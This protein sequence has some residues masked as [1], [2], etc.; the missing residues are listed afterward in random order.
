[1]VNLMDIGVII[2]SLKSYGGAQ[3]C[4]L[5]C[6]NLWQK[7][8]DITLYT[9]NYD[10]RITENYKLDIDIKILNTKLFPRNDHYHQFF[11]LS[12]KYLHKQV[13]DHDIFNPHIF[14]SFFIHKNP[15][16]YYPQEPLRIAYDLFDFT[17]Q[18][19]DISNYVKFSLKL[20]MP[21]LKYLDKKN[22]KF[23]SIVANSHFSKKYLEDTYKK[24]CD[25]VYL[26]VDFENFKNSDSENFIL[27]VSRFDSAKRIE[28]PI[29]TMRYLNSFKMK[30]VGKGSEFTT[31]KLK[32]LVKKLKL[33]DKIE[34]IEDIN[35]SKLIELY[36]KCFCTIFTPLREPF[37]M[38]ALESMAA[39][40]P[41]IGCN[42]GGFTEVI[43]NGKH[44]FLTDPNPKILAD[45][46]RFLK[47]NPEIYKK[48]S[49]EC[50]KQASKFTWQKTADGLMDIFKEYY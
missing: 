40:K 9:C 36:S 22:A 12:M 25:V 28:I 14:P 47:D 6:I 11:P 23:D 49:K 38:V 26:G 44:G 43:E 5:E 13:G 10:E 46:I 16:V 45:K 18:R 20:Y 41:V 17:M 7:Y 4:V 31:N 35:E 21:F 29:L 42:E 24:E 37:G 8:N 1:M 15:S 19:E 30:I 2:P 34:F 32:E 33:T 48:M 27:F 3:K 39:G 50:E